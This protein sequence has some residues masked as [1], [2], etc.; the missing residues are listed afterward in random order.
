MSG[1]I[2]TSVPPPAAAGT[3]TP[4]EPLT[5][6]MWMSLFETALAEVSN[7]K[8]KDKLKDDMKA[9]AK[10]LNGAVRAEYDENAGTD[11]VSETKL[12][13]IINDTFDDFPGLAGTIG[14]DQDRYTLSDE[15]VTAYNGWCKNAKDFGENKAKQRFANFY[16]MVDG[17]LGT[18]EGIMC[19]QEDD[20]IKY[21][22]VGG[23][24]LPNTINNNINYIHVPKTVTKD[25]KRKLPSPISMNGE[26]W[27]PD[28]LK[29]PLK[30]PTKPPT[31]SDGE[32]MTAAE[33][34]VLKKYNED[35]ETYKKTEE[36]AIPK[37]FYVG[38]G[39]T[40]YY[41]DKYTPTEITFGCED[42]EDTYTP[43]NN[44]IRIGTS[45]KDTVVDETKSP[46]ITAPEITKKKDGL[47]LIVDFKTKNNKMFRVIT[48]HLSSGNEHPK[49]LDEMD[50]IIK[51]TNELTP[52]P[53]YILMDGNCSP[54]DDA[55]KTGSMTEKI[56]KLYPT[57][58]PAT[59]T[60]VAPKTWFKRIWGAGLS[61]LTTLKSRGLGTQQLFKAD[62][63]AKQIDWVVYIDNGTDF[64]DLHEISKG[65]GSDA[66]KKAMEQA[67]ADKISE[68]AIPSNRTGF[69]IPAGA[70][71]SN[72][73][74]WNDWSSDHFP[75]I[76]IG[77]YGILFTQLNCL[78]IW[79]SGDGFMTGK[80]WLKAAA[81]VEPEEAKAEA[82]VE[83]VE[84]EGAAAAVEA[85]EGAAWGAGG[86]NRRTGNRRTGNR[87]TG[88]RRTGNRRTGNRRT[89]NRRT[90][91][92]RRGR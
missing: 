42:K 31:K 41:G 24:K 61:L 64:L 60:G 74:K 34:A 84:A 3:T 83:A 23:W 16:E 12:T 27:A 59:A 45:V 82:K 76:F 91:R 1:L 79:A 20:F 69:T 88:N 55:G 81:A 89:G 39:L 40:I 49:R 5:P 36:E 43:D 15:F 6:Q 51:M 7:K 28:K 62:P 70:D 35:M 80:N 13:K 58:A 32:E 29:P 38:D 8:E 4:K 21:H 17:Q 66:V 18:G 22:L 86:G 57:T 73:E 65:E 30:K 26:C 37:Y 19:V 14:Y 46:G 72:L 75:V 2:D 48:T 25:G 52:L 11:G 78:A 87:R 54:N 92:K 10:E 56:N 9:F 47:F 44:S 50:H 33:K 77:I 68:Y 63:I 67:G 53:T 90:V 85:A 71:R